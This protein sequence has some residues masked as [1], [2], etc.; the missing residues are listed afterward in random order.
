[1]WHKII[2]LKKNEHRFSL[3]TSLLNK[4][5][6]FKPMAKGTKRLTPPSSCTRHC[7]RTRRTQESN[8]PWTIRSENRKNTRARVSKSVILVHNLLR[9]P[10][11]V[12]T[13]TTKTISDKINSRESVPSEWFYFNLLKYTHGPVAKVYFFFFICK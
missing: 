8:S 2:C 12:S 9:C 7:I 11:A 13:N 10:P 6:R 4:Y 3:G 1:M 5:S